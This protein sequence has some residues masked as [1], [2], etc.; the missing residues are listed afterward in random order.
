M[1]CTVLKRN[2]PHQKKERNKQIQQESVQCIIIWS[3][4]YC[5][6][7]AIEIGFNLNTTRIK[8]YKKHKVI[9]VFWC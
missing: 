1:T 3:F 4:M 7:T 9:A 5:W 2:K 6:D 8:P